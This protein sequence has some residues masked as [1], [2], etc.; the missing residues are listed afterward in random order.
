MFRYHNLLISKMALLQKNKTLKKEDINEIGTQMGTTLKE[1]ARILFRDHGCP[2][3]L[4]QNI[5]AISKL[6]IK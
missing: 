5:A 3:Q 6:D 4:M 2:E 1:S